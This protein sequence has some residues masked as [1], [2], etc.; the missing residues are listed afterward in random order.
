MNGEKREQ[1]SEPLPGVFQTVP[2]RELQKRKTSNSPS[3]SPSSKPDEKAKLLAFN[4]VRSRKV[5]L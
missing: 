2:S 1:A 4:R 5:Y 3:N